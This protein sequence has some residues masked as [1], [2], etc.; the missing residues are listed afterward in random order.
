MEPEA[1]LLRSRAHRIALEAARLLCA[2]DAADHAADPP[3]VNALLSLQQAAGRFAEVARRGSPE[4]RAAEQTSLEAAAALATHLDRGLAEAAEVLEVEHRLTAFALWAM[5]VIGAIAASIAV[6]RKSVT[7]DPGGPDDDGLDPAT[8]A[9][10]R[11]AIE[12][13]TAPAAAESERP[14]SDLMQRLRQRQARATGAAPP[15]PPTRQ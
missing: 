8:P 6:P 11:P 9:A 7:A 13:P 12:T 1:S 15:G 2:V 3:L 5:L 10:P 4:A 14:T